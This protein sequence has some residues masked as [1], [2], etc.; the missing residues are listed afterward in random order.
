MQIII[1]DTETTGLTKPAP[2]NIKFQPFLTEIF[3]F[4]I[5]ENFRKI[6]EFESMVRPPIPISK[7]ITKITGITNEDVIDA[8]VFFE[9]YDKLYEFFCGVDVVVGHNVAFDIDILHYEL[10]R[11]D[12][13]KKFCYPKK[14]ICTVEA[15]HHLENKRLN[16]Q[17]LHE[18]LF[19]EGFEDAHRARF[20]VM[21]TA[22][23]F[24]EMCTRGEIII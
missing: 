6:S 14:H 21:A 11:H 12:L 13:E 2:T 23:C 4:K 18:H 20:D 3:C 7:E 17:K 10:L 15:S 24:V 16:L 19:A 5:D 8:P 1:F 22:R 9:I